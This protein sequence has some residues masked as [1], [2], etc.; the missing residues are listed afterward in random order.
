MAALLTNALGQKTDYRLQ[1]LDVIRIQ[2]LE[3]FAGQINSVL[4]I[5]KDGTVSAPFVGT[6]RA[7]GKSTA[8]LESELT[9]LYED[10]LK[11]RDPHVAVTVEQY[12]SVQA[13]ATGMVN[14]PGVYDFR[15]GDSLMTL[16]S[17][18]GGVNVDRG[19]LG[20]ATLKHRN[21]RELIPID[22]H[23]ML[24]LQDMSQN[25]DLQDGDELNV[26]EATQNKILIMGAIQAPGTYVYKEPMRLADAIS[27]AK[28]PIPIRSMMSK[29]YV[30]RQVP[31]HPG[32]FRRIHADFVKFIRKGDNS[33][34]IELQAGDLVYV[35]ETNTPDINTV[36][37]V[38][39]NAAF[40]ISKFFP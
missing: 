6:V 1:P 22:L 30:V 16:I 40:L 12:R 9:Q 32:Q 33:Q 29:V 31:G 20:H 17:K 36:T 23:A 38:L 3:V 19:D 14:S 21:S 13:S 15:P 18:S 8:E 5:A 28:G 2:V 4:P 11:L 35:S 10:R 27:E 34:N 26:P 25:Y 39:G 7:A 24:Y 37:N